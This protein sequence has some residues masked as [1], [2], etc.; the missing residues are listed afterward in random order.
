MTLVAAGTVTLGTLGLCELGLRA[1]TPLPV[2]EW[3]NQTPDSLLLYRVDPAL[4]DVDRHGFRNPDGTAADL[5]AIGDSHTYGNNV[6][7]FESWP[8]LVGAYNMGVGSYSIYQYAVL[9]D[10]ALDRGATRV[11]VGLYPANDLGGTVGCTLLNSAAWAGRVAHDSLETCPPQ[12]AV[13]PVRQPLSWW[14]VENLA[15]ANLFDRVVTERLV[16]P[17]SFD[18]GGHRLPVRL[19]A[20]HM[21]ATRLDS[22]QNA[23]HYRNSVRILRRMA[24]SGRLAVVLIPSKE[25]VLAEWSDDVP[26]AVFEAVE[27]ERALAEKWAALLD[28]LGVPVTTPLADLVSTVSDAPLYP[29]FDGHPYSEG[30]RA[31]ADAA[32]EALRMLSGDATPD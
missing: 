3:S 23:L 8:A 27:S 4:P 18:I 2:N 10:L 14:M 19:V 29:P 26:A 7:S 6:A 16:T 21:R 22:A 12:P 11:V 24:A 9:F 13:A 28:S 1:L 30:Y 25:A 31:Y 17:E 32:R 5:V 15:L 20:S